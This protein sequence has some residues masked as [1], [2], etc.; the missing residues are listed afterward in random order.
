MWAKLT[1]IN[2]QT[3]NQPQ[4]SESPTVEPPI[5]GVSISV[6]LD[7]SKDW[8]NFMNQHNRTASGNL[9]LMTPE[10]L[11]RLKK[12]K[13]GFVEATIN[14]QLIGTMVV[15]PMGDVSHGTFLCIDPNFRGQ[16]IAP[17]LIQ[18]GLNWCSPPVG[19]FLTADKK[20]L[21][22]LPIYRWYRPINV[23]RARELGFDFPN[24]RRP[25]DRTNARDILHYSVKNLSGLKVLN[26]TDGPISDW[27]YPTYRIELN[28]EVIGH[29][30]ME[31]RPIQMKNGQ[32][33]NIGVI[34]WAKI[35]H[36]K[37]FRGFLEIGSREN[38]D[39]IFGYQVS[40]ITPEVLN[41]FNAIPSTPMYLGWANTGRRINAVDWDLPFL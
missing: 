7:P 32:I 4:I 13:S 8:M 2:R 3:W 12:I 23:S 38:V 33:G 9:N 1:P 5:P 37:A 22:S 34:V 28:D 24:Y 29:F 11:Q 39:I 40:G 19:Y 31:V 25:E 30:S 35:S 36:P 14:D 21:T 10:I 26:S 18:T 16:R 20:T 27:P 41:Q 6:S 15:I 17:Q